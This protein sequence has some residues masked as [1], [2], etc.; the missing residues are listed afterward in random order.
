MKLRLLRRGFSESEI[1]FVSSGMNLKIAEQVSAQIKKYDVIWLGRI[2]RQKGID[3]LLATLAFLS[4]EIV[5]F[6]AVLVGRLDE[7]APRLAELN[8]SGCV[9]LSGLVSEEE[10]FR[11]FKSSRIFLMPSRQESWGIVIAEAL[12]C[13]V[14]VV[15]YDLP[16]YRPIFG[17][18]IE[19]VPCFD[20]EIFK[21]KS[22]ETV[23]K[24]RCGEIILDEQKLQQ[25]KNEHS[26]E[27]SGKRFAATARDF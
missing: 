16:A 14:P 19:Y 3:D 8:L 17:S 7:L 26:L 11:L 6:R 20:F 9:K 25:L 27:M 4:K 2:H 21:N 12:A 15:A 5:D 1:V 10:K 22:L 23:E 13:D 24:A 18:L